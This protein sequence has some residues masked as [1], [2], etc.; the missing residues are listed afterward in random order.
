MA[1]D[2][3]T[4]V[5]DEVVARYLAHQGHKHVL[6]AFQQA[7]QREDLSSDQFKD[8]ARDLRTLVEQS[9]SIASAQALA[10]LQLEETD[11]DDLDD[12]VVRA[13]AAGTAEYTLD[14]TI[15]HLHHSNLLSIRAVQVPERCGTA[16]TLREGIATTGA[17]KLIVF[18]EPH[19]GE[20]FAILDKPRQPTPSGAVGHDSAVLDV[21]QNPKCARYVASAGMDGRVVVW[22]LVGRAMKLTQHVAQPVQTLKEHARFVVRVA[23]SPCGTFLASAGYDKKVVVYRAMRHGDDLTY[24]KVHELALAANP[25]AMVFVVGPSAPPAPGQELSVPRRAWLV[26]SERGR[27]ELTYV[28]LPAPDLEEGAAPDFTTVKYNTNPDPDDHHAGY[29]LLDLS[30][31][32]SGRYLCAQTGDH[33]ALQRESPMGPSVSIGGTTLGDTLSRLLVLPLFS[34]FR[35]LTLWTEAPSST[36]S[37][38][39]HAW[40]AEG[41]AAW[42]TGED[43]VLRLVGLDG[44]IKARVPAHGQLPPIDSTSQRVRDA[45]AAAAWVRGGNTVIKGVAVLPDGGVASCGFDRTVRVLRASVSS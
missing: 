9:Q 28:A 13:Q 25:E 8:V 12:L 14:K 33:A 4:E 17:D 26:F 2:A 21:S 38:P 32:P 39:R 43:G 1:G 34:S 41:D 3:L 44:E 6:E 19:T 37:N 22:D 45:A 20:V 27:V 16:W 30:V 40:R 18:S 42:V 23:H 31:H 7:V 10:R 35:R 5:C 29:S 11:A 36:F 15:E 24:T